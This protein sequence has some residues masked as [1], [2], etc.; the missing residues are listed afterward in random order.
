VRTR[1]CVW[2]TKARTCCFQMAMMVEVLPVVMPH[3]AG[4][5]LMCALSLLPKDLFNTKPK[6][7]VKSLT[8]RTAA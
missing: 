3:E 4:L 8:S 7:V 1:A 5:V 2:A 6:L